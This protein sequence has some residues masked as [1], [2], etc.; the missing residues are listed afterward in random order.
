MP[1]TG[2]ALR[3]AVRGGQ[4]SKDTAACQDRSKFRTFYMG[5]QDSELLPFPAQNS[6]QTAMLMGKTGE[7]M[8]VCALRFILVLTAR[9]SRKGNVGRM[10]E[11]LHKA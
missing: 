9:V 10:Q 11:P 8:H 3:V 1:M 6:V 5:D 7:T 2:P 4:P